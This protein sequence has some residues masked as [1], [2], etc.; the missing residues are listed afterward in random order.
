MGHFSINQ[1]A[2]SAVAQQH[3]ISNLPPVAV[4]E[5]IK[6]LIDRVLE[7]LRTAFGKPII[8]NSGYRSPQLN[9]LVHGAANSQHMYGY[10]A[11][12]TSVD[13]KALWA[14]AVKMLE[15]GKLPIDQLIDEQDLS[16]IH[17]SHVSGRPNRHQVFANPV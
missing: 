4:V 12:I 2:R 15:E 11:D 1:F 14:L 6:H 9:A 8:I 5:N 17:I 3:G 16:W 10:A 7:P 13:N